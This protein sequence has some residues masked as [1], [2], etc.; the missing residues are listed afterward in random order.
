[1]IMIEIQYSGIALLF[2]VNPCIVYQNNGT[3][4]LNY[5]YYCLKGRC[6]VAN[7]VQPVIQ[8]YNCLKITSAIKVATMKIIDD[9]R[10]KWKPSCAY[11]KI[12]TFLDSKDE[13]DTKEG[14]SKF[15]KNAL[16]IQQYIK[17]DLSG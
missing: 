8:H 11:H 1:M 13:W 4:C 6:F 10:Y 2:L 14:P 5:I 12:D 17:R 16:H 3:V 9:F 7:Y 15:T